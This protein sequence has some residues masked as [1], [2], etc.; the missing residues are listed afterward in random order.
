MRRAHLAGRA[1]DEP[2]LSLAAWCR[3]RP[4]APTQDGGRS[5]CLQFFGA[6]PSS[7]ISRRRAY[8]CVSLL[9][10]ADGVIACGELRGD[11]ALAMVHTNDRA[12]FACPPTWCTGGDSMAT[13][14]AT[15]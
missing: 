8:C 3:Q 5:G 4:A 1:G 11:D 2:P 9:D 13:T 7:P 10:I 14:T 6:S 15:T 12:A